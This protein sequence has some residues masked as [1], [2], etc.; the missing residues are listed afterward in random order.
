MLY[1][2]LSL[3]AFLASAADVVDPPVTDPCA[4]TGDN[5]AI[6]E[7]QK[8]YSGTDYGKECGDWDMDHRYCRNPKS[9]QEANRACWCPKFWCYVSKECEH[10]KRSQFFK[11]AELYYSYLACGND[12]SICF[13]D[14]GMPDSEGVEWSEALD[15]ENEEDDDTTL[16]QDVV[17]AVVM[18]TLKMNDMTKVL[19]SLSTQVSTLNKEATELGATILNVPDTPMLMPTVNI[20]T[21]DDGEVL[22]TESNWAETTCPLG[23]EMIKG[24]PKCKEA[25][26]AMRYEW[27]G[28]DEKEARGG[29]KVCVYS[30]AEQ[31]TAGVQIMRNVATDSHKLICEKSD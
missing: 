16:L 24:T 29:E 31:P 20:A 9:I 5:S 22:F 13:E 14:D 15:E 21:N 2:L 30:A 19:N 12:E 11:D 17:D 27:I 23:Y 8:K 1:L 3:V 4:C 28:G 10:G 18:I 6:P 25:A 7:K 26:K